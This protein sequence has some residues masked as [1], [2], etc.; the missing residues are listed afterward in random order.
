MMCGVHG[1]GKSATAIKLNKHL[2][3]YLYI[4]SFAGPVAKRMGFDLN[5]PHTADKLMQYQ[6]RLLE[7]FIE[8]YK[9]TTYVP[10][11][12]DR[13]PIDLAAYM[14]YAQ[15]NHNLPL[16]AVNKFTRRCVEATQEYCDI[17]V[18]PE[19]DLSEAM[20]AKSNRPSAYDRTEFDR[21]IDSFVMLIPND[22]PKV[23]DVPVQYQ[24]Q[25]R[26]NYILEQIK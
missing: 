8:S 18:Y 2:P 23:I 17:L 7:V 20:E 4:P 6:E 3:D 25:D 11:I 10:T 14:T 15:N 16:V 13:S 19:A 24:Y 5:Q 12:Y 22:K 26:V 21:I 1:I 9:A